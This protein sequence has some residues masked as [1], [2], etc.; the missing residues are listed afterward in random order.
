M[1]QEMND[2]DELEKTCVIFKHSTTCPISA[3]AKEEM[4]LVAGVPIYLVVVQ[5]QRGLSDEIA[6]QF[7][8]QHESPQAIVIVDGEV[9]EVLNHS[10]ITKEAIEALLPENTE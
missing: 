5:E 1:Y 9:Q 7:Q 6:Q 8:I 4:D 3:A 2:L 10:A